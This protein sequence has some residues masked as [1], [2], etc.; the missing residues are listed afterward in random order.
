VRLPEVSVPPGAEE[1]AW[2]V[3]RAAFEEREPVQRPRSRLRPAIALAAAALVAGV[4]ASPP[5]WSLIH[6]IRKAVGVEGAKTELFSLPAPGRLLVVSQRGLWTVQQDGSRRLLG[7]YRDGAWSPFGHYLAATR[8]NELLALDTKGNV[9][10]ELA[11]PNVSFPTWTGSLTNTRIAYLTKRSLH[12]VAGDSTGDESKCADLV[13]S[14]APAWQPHSL[15]ILAFAAPNGQVHV[16]DVTACRL[17]LRSAPGPVPTKLAW[18]SD[19]RQLLALSPFR[20]RVYDQRGHVVAEDDPSDAT[21]DADATFLPGT[22]RVA[23]IRVHGAQSDVFELGTGRTIFRSTGAFRQLVASPDGRWLLVTWPTANQ[24]VFVRM[25]GPRRIVA[26]SQITRQ[27]GGSARV[28]GW[29][30]EK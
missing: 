27:F 21:M 6:S 18:S 12:V 9:R 3:V 13:A 20:L 25:R 15:S 5:G 2:Q 22:H 29:C 1:R 8:R 19:G 23:V 14:V 24:W 26:V 30:C 4:L 28:A 16:Y 7:L 17:L 10:W 11:R